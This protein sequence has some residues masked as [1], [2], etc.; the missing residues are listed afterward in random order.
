MKFPF[1]PEGLALVIEVRGSNG[2]LVS[3]LND[4]IDQCKDWNTKY[5]QADSPDS[6]EPTPDTTAGETIT[7]L[8]IKKAKYPAT[9]YSFGR[10]SGC[11]VVLPRVGK[12]GISGTHFRIYISEYGTWMLRNESKNGTMIGGDCVLGSVA[13]R[14]GL[15]NTVHVMDIKLSIHILT[16]WLLPFRGRTPAFPTSSRN[17]SSGTSSS[18]FELEPIPGYEA[19]VNSTYHILQQRITP[20]GS[21]YRAIHTL[22]GR[23]VVAIRCIGDIKKSQQ[24]YKLI[25][26]LSSQVGSL[27]IRNS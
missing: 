21:Q 8:Q 9:G 11:F 16:E 19:G 7:Y 27:L 23:P 6:R 20:E 3:D 24:R 17:S 13:L 22:T 1:D 14:P 5:G 26:T 12:K 2:P 25:S 15:D 4:K 10:S 18:V